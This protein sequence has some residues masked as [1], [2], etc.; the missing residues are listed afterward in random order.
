MSFN[1]LSIIC[2]VD[3][4]TTPKL[5]NVYPSSLEQQ[6]NKFFRQRICQTLQTFPS[7]S[8]NYHLQPFHLSFL[9][10]VLENYERIGEINGKTSKSSMELFGNTIEMLNEEIIIE[11]QSYFSDYD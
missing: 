1:K 2:H 7:F 8:N 3:F 5:F 10:N 11:D 4:L 6:V 9:Q